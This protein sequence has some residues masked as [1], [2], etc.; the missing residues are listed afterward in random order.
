MRSSRVN[1]SLTTEFSLVQETILIQNE[2]IT[3]LYVIQS[4]QNPF[5]W[6]GVLFVDSGIYTGSAVRFN[7]IIDES[8]PDCP[9][10]QIIFDPIPYHPLINPSTGQL[11]TKN[12]FPNWNSKD[13]KLFELLLF[14][15]RVIRQADQYIVQIRDL[16]NQSSAS[17]FPTDDVHENQSDSNPHRSH[18]KPKPHSETLLE[19]QDN[20]NN[21]TS[22]QIL[23][24][25]SPSL[26]NLFTSFHHTLDF[27]NTYENDPDE[28]QR[29]VEEFKHL[30]CQ[31][32]L[33]RPPLCGDDGNALI[34]S[35]WD[36][37]L[38]EPVRNCI[39]GGRFTPTNLFA[40]YHR[41]TDSVSFIP[42]HES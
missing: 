3:Q 23:E 15:K 9:C 19:K 14:V 5:V 35:P 1:C 34:F 20:I 32:L 27:I 26:T 11:D 37:E 6:F 21:S 29:K 2:R 7:L 42:G 13:N 10:P 12:A 18:P 24:N 38:H 25:F 28:F 41:E 36:L 39:L 40:S 22:E 16:I 8:Y 33:D 30:C 31:Q 17:K 4:E